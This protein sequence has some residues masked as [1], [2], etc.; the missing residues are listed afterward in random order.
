MRPSANLWFQACRVAGFGQS[1]NGKPNPKQVVLPD[2][3]IY[4]R[5]DTLQLAVLHDEFAAAL[6]ENR[7]FACPGEMGLRDIRIV[8]ALYRS[9]A[10]NGERVKVEAGPSMGS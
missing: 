4:K 10:Q 6:R 2:G 5:P 3:S 7:P 8:E 1:G 9:V